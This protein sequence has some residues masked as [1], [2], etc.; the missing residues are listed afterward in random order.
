MDMVS[1]S[2]WLGDSS[3]R[4]VEWTAHSQAPPVEHVG[5]DHGGGDMLVTKQILDGA[6]VVAVL[7]HVRLVRV[8]LRVGRLQLLL[9]RDLPEEEAHAVLVQLVDPVAGSTHSTK[10]GRWPKRAETG[11][12]AQRPVRE[13]QSPGSGFRCSARF[14]STRLP[15]GFHG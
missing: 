10:W 15:P 2:P 12:G 8:V 3:P 11:V 5:V 6:D 7:E 9:H 14:G 4:L 13:T 1:A